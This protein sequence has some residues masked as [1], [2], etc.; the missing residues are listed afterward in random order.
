MRWRP[1]NC[2][3]W[4]GWLI[5]REFVYSLPANEGRTHVLGIGK[6][7]A[8]SVNSVLGGAAVR[9]LRTAGAV[10]TLTMG[11]TA[12][13]SSLAAASF[14]S[15][16][17]IAGLMAGSAKAL[18]SA[19]SASAEGVSIAA[20]ISSGA[21]QVTSLPVAASTAAVTYYVP[22]F[23]GGGGSGANPFEGLNLPPP[24]SGHK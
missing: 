1:R 6:L 17:P 5:Q 4:R 22:S 9:G 13:S 16:G 12:V 8:R 7:I 11:Q 21:V 24:S 2:S 20:E 10:A 15:R 19:G 14:P 23:R 18:T 3:L